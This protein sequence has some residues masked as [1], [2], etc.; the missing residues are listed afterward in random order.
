MSAGNTSAGWV[1][2]AAAA[3][4]VAA[5]AGA[6][7]LL[8]PR[9]EEP[10][11]PVVD[12]PALSGEDVSARVHQFCGAC[13]AYPPP[14]TFPRSAWKKEVER[15][16]QFFRDSYLSLQPPPIDAVIKY[17][18]AGAPPELPAA[19][20]PRAKTPLGVRFER[21]GFAGPPGASP[22]AVANVSLVKLSDPKRLEVLAC[23]M[24]WGLVMALRPWEDRP[25]WRVL[26]K[27]SHPARAE[28]VD[29]DGDGINDLLVANLG[30][31]TPTDGLC[32]SVV[33]LRGRADGGYTS[34][35][36]LEGLG[37]VADVRAD[38]FRGGKQRD[39]VVAVFGWQKEGSMLYL[40][41]QTTDWS[42]PKFVKK[43][44]L[45]PR[46]GT[47]HVPVVDLNGDGRPDFVALISQEHETVVAFLN[48]GNGQFRK[49][50]LYT[51]PHP[52]YGSSGIQ[53]VDLNGDGKKDILY[54]NGDVLDEPHL[55]KPYHS[56]QWLEN[57]GGLRFEHHHLAAMY[58]VHRAV[59]ADIDGDG[60]QDIVAV[61]F[62]PAEHFPQ[63]QPMKLDSVIVLE[64]TA[65]GRFARHTLESSTC[66]HVSCA[67]GDLFGT[68][69][70]DLVIGNFCAHK[71]DHAVTVWRNRGR[72]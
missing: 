39:L 2:L 1:W 64:Q 8:Q 36:L 5:G 42:K 52:G 35:T 63:R 14:E 56:I 59:A 7:I 9:P 15:G 11:P 47:I 16:Y 26:G 25:S 22:P 30:S 38:F 17:Y 55:L 20:I 70:A 24:R 72:K 6:Y 50:T 41:N 65:P 37:R 4:L 44:V 54:T 29:L 33:W 13:H 67:A 28:V 3:G 10:P 62:L 49:Q 51:A 45:D 57:K 31:F 19:V 21:S 34:H 66:D 46:H 27:V 71:V 40:E 60:D 32:G 58:G 69:R 53:L 68:G 12:S 18:E 48:E 61:S 43:R 23:E